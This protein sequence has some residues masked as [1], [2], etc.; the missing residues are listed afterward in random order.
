MTIE[1][2]SEGEVHACGEENRGTN[3]ITRAGPRSCGRP[4]SWISSSLAVL[5]GIFVPLALGFA[6]PLLERDSG[7]RALRWLFRHAELRVLLPEGSEARDQLDSLLDAESEK[8][9]WT[10]RQCL[11]VLSDGRRRRQAQC[12]CASTSPDTR[13]REHRWRWVLQWDHLLRELVTCESTCTDRAKQRRMCG[14]AAKFE[15]E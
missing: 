4:G 7:G 2:A 10:A 9:V 13:R 6:K 12:L 11:T 5:S 3:S 1:R 14:S 8:L 15:R